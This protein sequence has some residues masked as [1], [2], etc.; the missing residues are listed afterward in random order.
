MTSTYD[1]AEPLG[2]ILGWREIARVTGRSRAW[3]VFWSGP[4]A[5]EGRRLPIFRYGGRPALRRESL[6]KWVMDME[7]AR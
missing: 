3:C 5:P 6:I 2:I 4:M 7:R 1:P